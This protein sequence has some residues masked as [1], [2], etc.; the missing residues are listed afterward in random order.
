ML[1]V[2]TMQLIAFTVLTAAN[3]TV[4]AVAATFSYY[5]NYGLKP[6]ILILSQGFG[7]EDAYIDFEV[8]NRRKYPIVVHGVEIRFG[9]V[10]IEQAGKMITPWYIFHNT[11]CHR[12]HV[13]LEPASHHLFEA[14]VPIEKQTLSKSETVRTDVFYF[15]PIANRR[16]KLTR[17]HQYRYTEEG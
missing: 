3:V 14:S 7:E 6:V 16:K 11:L 12:E 8:W 5:Q 17:K 1:D 10:T 4:A 13:R 2:P 15:D 9:N